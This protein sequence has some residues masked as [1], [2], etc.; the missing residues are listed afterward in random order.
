MCLPLFY[1]DIYNFSAKW[2][3]VSF[4]LLPIKAHSTWHILTVPLNMLETSLLLLLDIMK[5]NSS[6]VMRHL[7]CLLDLSN[8]EN[9]NLSFL[10][11]WVFKLTTS[12][13]YC[14]NFDSCSLNLPRILELIYRLHLTQSSR[15][16]YCAVVVE[17]H[18]YFSLCL[19]TF[20]IFK[21][22]VKCSYKYG[23]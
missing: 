8:L 6:M 13:W 15:R 2:N 3:L 17:Y 20:V 7:V 9:H 14:R 19:L 18:P 4:I 21:Y 11:S 22:Y 10:Y 12:L 1:N 16:E 5:N 23:S